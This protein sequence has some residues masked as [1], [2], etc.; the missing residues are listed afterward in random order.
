LQALD[1]AGLTGKKDQ[2]ANALTLADMKRL[3]VARA[4][5]TRPRLLLLDEV[6]AGLNTTE[7]EEA[8]KLV[9]H[10]RDAGITVMV[11]EHVM[12]AIMSV[13]ERILVIAQG[14]KIMEGRPDEAIADTRVVKAY[15]GEGFE[16]T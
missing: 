6:M 11:V 12:R 7:I 4:L 2:P 15:L 9:R 3:E 14:E 16:L 5:A 10:I 1:L 13:S 8:I